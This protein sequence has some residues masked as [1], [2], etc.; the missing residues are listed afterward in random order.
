LPQELLLCRLF[1]FAFTERALLEAQL[2]PS[3][4]VIDIATG[5]GTMAVVAARSE[6]DVLATDVSPAMI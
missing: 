5:I 3:S 1:W 2:S 4:K 6:M